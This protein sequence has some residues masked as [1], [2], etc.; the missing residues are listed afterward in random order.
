MQ[1]QLYQSDTWIGTS[2]T[3]ASTRLRQLET[4]RLELLLRKEDE[5][6]ES[7]R[8]LIDLRC[9]ELEKIIDGVKSEL[10][11]SLKDLQSDCF[12]ADL[13]RTSLGCPLRLQLS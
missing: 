2:L 9:K 7:K 12:V 1:L 6:K 3:R 5:D 11:T 4:D 8:D 10:N 13:M